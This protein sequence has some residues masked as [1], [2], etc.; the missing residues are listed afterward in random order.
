MSKKMKHF[1]IHTLH[2]GPQN[3]GQDW[4]TK[5][6]GTEVCSGCYSPLVSSSSLDI[7]ID[8]NLEDVPL[9]IAMPVAIG[10]IRLDLLSAFDEDEFR[11][12]FFV[13]SVRDSSGQVIEDFFTFRG[14]SQIII[15]GGVGSSHR[16]CESCGR[17]LYHPI[18]KR[19]VLESSLDGRPFYESQLNQII[20]SEIAANRLLGDSW[21]RLKIAPLSA[22]AKA[23]DGMELVGN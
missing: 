15:R 17:H 20:S 4:L 7:Q 22:L 13:G 2:D 11:R 21:E 10:I 3:V 8:D 16:V 18:G 5:A 9:N 12:Y 14:K 23:K 19:Y 6:L 1:H